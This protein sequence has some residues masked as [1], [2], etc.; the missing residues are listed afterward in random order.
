[1]EFKRHHRTY[2]A[3]K[4]K[5]LFFGCKTRQAYN[6]LSE[7][8]YNFLLNTDLSEITIPSLVK[9]LNRSYGALKR[10]LDDNKIV[11][12]KIDNTPI[13]LSIVS[14]F[15]YYED[16]AEALNRSINTIRTIC[17]KNNISLKSKTVDQRA[18]NYNL[19]M[20]ELKSRQV[21][22]ITLTEASALYKQITKTSIGDAQ[23]KKL[24][25]ATD[26]KLFNI[27]NPEWTSEYIEIL[28][29]CHTLKE[30]KNKLPFGRNNIIAFMEENGISFKPYVVERKTARKIKCIE[31]NEVHV[32]N[33]FSKNNYCDCSSLY[34]ALRDKT[35]TA[36]GYHW[37]YVKDNEE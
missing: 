32:A 16:A 5:A 36:G 17:Y 15:T 19:F 23:L 14:S 21:Q 7:S 30:A 13:D 1:M 2:E 10:F 4:R 11:Y 34:R 22:N 3:I 31:T 24:L 37:E 29:Q 26:V 6:G 33:Y 9:K 20:T 8:E 28:K 27:K 35:K 25:A 12:K 18:A